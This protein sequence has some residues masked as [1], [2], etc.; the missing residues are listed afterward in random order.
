MP[1]AL[2][3]VV[4]VVLAWVVSVEAGA[5]RPRTPAEIETRRAEVSERLALVEHELAAVMTLLQSLP[6]RLEGA[7]AAAA[8]ALEAQRRALE[9]RRAALAAEREALQAEQAELAALRTR[10]STGPLQPSDPQG[11]SPLDLGGQSG[12]VSSGQAF[13][14]S[15]SVIPDV[16][17]YSDDVGGGAFEIVEGADGLGGGHEHEGPS[18]G[19]GHGT[20][21]RGFNL[22][23]ME[24]AFSG[25]VDPYFDVWATV[26][27]GPD[28]IEA[29][30]VYVQTRKFVPGL[31]LRVGRFF[32]GVGHVNRQHPHQWDFV[33]QALPHQALFGGTLAEA[34]VQ[35]TWL[36]NVPVYT[37]LG[38]EALQGE[39][40]RLSHQSGEE[41]P[42]LFE[43]TPG[44]R[45]FTG[46]MKVSPDVGY[47]HAL[48]G[49][50]SFGR[51]RSHQELIDDGQ[52]PS[53]QAFDGA[54]WFIGTDWVWR[55]DSARPF[56][57]G[58]LTVQG[59]YVYRKKDLSPV[60]SGAPEAGGPRVSA[61]DGV[62]A[63]AVYGIAPR[64][65]LAGRFDAIGLVNRIEVGDVAGEYGASHRYSAAVAF[66][67][68]E[69]SRLR[70][71]YNAGRFQRE[72]RAVF[73]Q[74][75][76]QFQM[77]LG[78]HGAH[79]F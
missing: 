79:R 70:V 44:P 28:S 60:T 78:V 4:F 74:V 53:P 9:A 76:V 32:S 17:Y 11:L 51:S 12:Q 58:D 37:L 15:I 21:D 52:G 47:S 66:N 33:D 59:E 63:Q 50:V 73:H 34:G 40:E 2:L 20:L 49:G 3:A 18:G 72:G 24:L 8:G 67:P 27:L 30:E 39:N 23:E 36:P 5:A 62:Y 6:A 22:R 1:T 25:A 13:N 54:A 35:V 61:Q 48:Q 69:F 75:F 56:G 77:S 46:F 57:Q 64:W 68:T 38:F 7:D 55:Y 31:Q 43:E 65:T 41:H 29:E 71:Q 16:V 10:T 14:P 26:A 42:G 19:H 45:L